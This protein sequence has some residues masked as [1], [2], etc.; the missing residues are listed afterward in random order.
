MSR[1][2]ALRV[3]AAVGC[4]A[5]WAVAAWGGPSVLAL[6]LLGTC[7]ALAGF[8]VW[9]AAAGMTVA[10]VVVVGSLALAAAYADGMGLVLRSVL[11]GVLLVLSLLVAG[12]AESLP[13]GCVSAWSV[14]GATL[15]SRRSLLVLAAASAAGAG[16][17]A[18][19]GPVRGLAPILLGMAAAVA[20]VWL[21]VRRVR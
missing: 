14:L 1:P 13:D 2:V 6:L 10:G 8:V 5:A 17:L 3:A 18:A 4:L 16:A 11:A 12:V 20:A 15:A 9:R 19:A 7:G 21:G